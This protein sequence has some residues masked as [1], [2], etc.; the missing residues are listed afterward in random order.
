MSLSVTVSHCQSISITVSHCQSLSATV[1][2]CKSY[3]LFPTPSL[4]STPFYIK[5]LLSEPSH[6]YLQHLYFFQNPTLFTGVLSLPP[7]WTPPPS[8]PENLFFRTLPSLSVPPQPCPPFKCIP[9]SPCP[10]TF[11]LLPYVSGVFKSQL[12]AS[13]PLKCNPLSP[14][15]PTFWPPPYM[16][17]V[18][19][20]QLF[21]PFFCL[22]RLNSCSQLTARSRERERS[23]HKALDLLLTAHSAF[24]RERERDQLT[25]LL[26]SCSQLTAL[27]FAGCH[28]LG[29]FCRHFMWLQKKG[30]MASDFNQTVSTTVLECFNSVKHCFSMF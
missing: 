17:G 7:P 2:H 20:S 22:R 19:K 16:T 8:L 9:L 29:E 1:S 5:P 25:R 3:F 13:P 6:S 24:E 4:S 26:N 11:L 23:A 28:K 15:P 27:Y 14:C 10:P 18:S 12:F 21:A 30:W